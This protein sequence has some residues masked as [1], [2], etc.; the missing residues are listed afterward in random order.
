MTL[1]VLLAAL[2]ILVGVWLVAAGSLGRWKRPA[3]R[4]GVLMML[5]G[6]A[7]L[8]GSVVPALFFAHRGPLVHLHLSYPSG[9]LRRRAAVAVTVAVYLASLA[10]GFLRLPWLTLTLA[11][12]VAL[13]AT[14]TFLRT[15]GP[16][17]K[18]AL[19]AL[20][21]ALA[22]AGILAVSSLNVLLRWG[23]DAPVAVA[24]DVTIAWAVA[25]LLLDL[26]T[27]R[28]VDATVT[29]LVLDLGSPRGSPGCAASSAEPS[30]TRRW[31]SG[32]G[33]RGARRT[34]TRAG[35]R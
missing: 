33:S 12:A 31:R 18:A 8:A 13:V 16:A 26:L 5:A 20:G 19:P 35:S 22:F 32:S 11:A 3:G 24:Y 10:E 30:A 6:A 14:D 1:R 25:I 28:W 34:S 27:S 15:T 21:A 7:W 29:D 23:V 4:V 9:R 2:D 17:R